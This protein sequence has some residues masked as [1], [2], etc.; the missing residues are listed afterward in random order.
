VIHVLHLLTSLGRGGAERALADIVAASDRSRFRHTLC[1]LHGPHDLAGD[2]HAA[3]CETICLDAGGGRAW[4]GGAKKLRPILAALEPD[5]VQSATFEANIA[6]RLAAGRSGP[7]LATW[8]VSMEYDPESVRAAGWPRGRN[9]IRRGLDGVTGRFT[10]SH[11]VAC[12]AS[13]MRSATE[14]LHIPQR[15]IETI[16]NLVNLGTLRTERGEAEALRGTLGLPPGAFVYLT[17]GRVDAAKDQRTLLRAFARVAADQPD[18]HLLLLGKG[19]LADSLAAEARALGVGDRVRFV[20]SAPRV[21]PFFALADVFVFPSLLEGLPV[22]LLEAMCAGLPS[23]ASDIEPHLE[24]VRQ[25]ETGL[26]FRRGSAEVLAAAMSRLYREEPLRAR[27]G[28]AAR[29]EAEALVSA[30]RVILQWQAT[31][32]RLARRS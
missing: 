27:L 29:E 23:I 7:P 2:F 19:G 5:I 21:A 13:V 16:Y 9:L 22:A 31:W 4:I 18:A 1:Y 32:E 17:I 24:V 14:R 6:A 3:G 11:Y 26:V 20:P 12:S 15:R 30:D 25:D 10:R 28:A 8:I